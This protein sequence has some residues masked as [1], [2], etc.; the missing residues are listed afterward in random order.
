MPVSLS[1]YRGA[2]AGM[3]TNIFAARGGLDLESVTAKKC[4][5]VNLL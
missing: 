2:V 3:I 4:N 5:R 1:Q